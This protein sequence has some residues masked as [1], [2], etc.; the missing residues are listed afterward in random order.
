M[1][2]SIAND[3]VVDMWSIGCIFAE[4]LGRKVIFQGR[5]HVDQ[6]FKILGILGLPKDI[7][8]WEPSE[9]ILHHLQSIC[10]VDGSPPPSEPVDFKLLFPDAND[11]AINLLTQL[12]NLNPY[13]RI[14]VEEAIQHR[15]L[16]AFADPAEESLVPP[17]S[18]PHLY[19][20]EQTNNDQDLKDMIIEEIHA[21]NICQE[22][23][24]D[25]TRKRYYTM[26]ITE[27]ATTHKLNYL[28]SATMSIIEPSASP[29]EDENVIYGD[30]QLVGEPE[31]L[32]EDDNYDYLCGLVKTT[33]GVSTI[34]GRELKEPEQTR[35]HL[36][37]VLSGTF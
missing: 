11:D 6:L 14:T 20:F 15:Y 1:I 2:N 5:D 30:N 18:L 8:F 25:S 27:D 33:P 4:I 10:T 12:L 13:N 36:E 34:P 32:D 23:R 31:E 21:F 28:P 37:K 26:A 7:S 3:I 16:Q 35:D 19:D 17:L 9:N 29:H 24:D 22:P